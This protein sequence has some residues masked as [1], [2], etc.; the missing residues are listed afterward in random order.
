M[1][2]R[3]VLTWLILVF[4]AAAVG[5]M[6]SALVGATE[7][8]PAGFGYIDYTRV[9]IALYPARSGCPFSLAGR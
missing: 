3:V 4:V 2:R 1:R 7:G 9:P 6:L 5:V 8:S